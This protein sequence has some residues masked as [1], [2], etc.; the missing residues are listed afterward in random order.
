MNEKSIRAPFVP[1]Q[2][3]FCSARKLPAAGCPRNAWKNCTKS[4]IEMEPRN[5]NG[6]PGLFTR[7]AVCEKMDWE[8]LRSFPIHK[9]K[10]ILPLSG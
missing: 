3:K 6:V 5:A 7:G 9:F 8:T 2:Q 4:P 1:E 10:I